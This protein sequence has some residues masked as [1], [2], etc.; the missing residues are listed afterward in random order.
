MLLGVTETWTNTDGTT[1]TAFVSDNVET[2]APGSPIFA[3]SGDD[4]LT[5]AGANDVFV[6]AQPIG[7][8]TIYNFNVASDKID[9]VKLC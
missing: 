9:L 3:W 8:D 5:G 1:G 6:F 4:T 7:N 2:Y